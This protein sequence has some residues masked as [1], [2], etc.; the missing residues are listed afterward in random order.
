M[1]S[2]FALG[3]DVKFCLELMLAALLDYDSSDRLAQFSRFIC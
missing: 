2:F 1:V 3:T